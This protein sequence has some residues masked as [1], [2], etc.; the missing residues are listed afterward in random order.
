MEI[1]IGNNNKAYR[2]DEARGSN[3]WLIAF[4]KWNRENGVNKIMKEM[5]QEKVWE[6]KDM[7]FKHK[8]ICWI[9][10]TLSHVVK[11][12]KRN[13]GKTLGERE[14]YTN[15]VRGKEVGNGMHVW[16]NP[17]PAESATKWDTI[18]SFSDIQR[19]K[20]FTTSHAPFIGKQ[21]ENIL[22]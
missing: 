4:Q 16:R 11:F 18:P 12:H 20:E 13:K 21:L 2:K 17:Y 9:L 22:D 7:S 14:R 8:S 10:G 3:V 15:K 19:L 1:E 5:Q 6:M